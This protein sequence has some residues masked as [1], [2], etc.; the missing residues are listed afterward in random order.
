MAM[1]SANSKDKSAM[2]SL[3]QEGDLKKFPQMLDYLV[4]KNIN[5]QIKETFTF[6]STNCLESLEILPESPYKDALKDIVINLDSRL[7]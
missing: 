1:K 4:K 6:Y 3:L 2:I 5:S 7:T